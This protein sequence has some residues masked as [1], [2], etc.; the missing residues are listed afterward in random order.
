MLDRALHEFCAIAVAGALS[1][2]ASVAACD[3]R[4]Q[5]TIPRKGPNPERLPLETAPPNVPEFRPAFAGQTRAPAVVTRTPVEV[6]EVATGLEEPW[7]IAFLPDH[8][9]LVTTK[10]SGKLYIVTATGKKSSPVAGLP[11]VD[12]RDQ[13]GLLDV[14]VAPD[15]A[16]SGR[17]YWTYY[18]P[19]TG[20]N[21]LT[22]A[23]ARLVEGTQPR[24]QQVQVL[25]RMQPTLDST[26]HAGGR[27]VFAPDGKLFV[28][29]GERFVP[30]GRAQAQDLRSHLGKIVR[31]NPDGSVP[32]DN[33]FIGRP[34]ARPEIWSSGHRNILAAALDRNRRLWIVEM[35][36]RGGDELNLIV[37]GKDYGWPMIGYGEDYSGEALHKTSQAPGLEQPI[38]YWDPV[39]SPSGLVIYS[40]DLFPEW[41]GN[42]L[43]GGLSSKALVR[44]VLENDRVIGEERLLTELGAR[45]REV[46]QGP[47]GAVYLLTDAI[48]GKLLKL[49]PEIQNPSK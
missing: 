38:Y 14:E 7:A 8:R 21:G 10:P 37:K 35:G 24:V 18:E 49:T 3:A 23:R 16:Q 13:G 44:L 32:D 2:V 6:N 36:P 33:P 4:G 47:D 9:M 5:D 27:M 17:I 20:G 46:A 39:I 43:I 22:V 48:D 45:I 41:K 1:V 34:D 11:P 15:F 28:T 26:K 12:G 31:I 19:R 30:E 29:L 40:G 25:F 42:F